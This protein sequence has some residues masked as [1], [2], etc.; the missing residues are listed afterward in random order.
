MSQSEGSSMQAPTSV[1]AILEDLVEDAP[2][3]APVNLAVFWKDIERRLL[4]QLRDEER[5]NLPL[6]KSVDPVEAERSRV[7]YERIR[8]LAWEVAVSIELGCVH[9]RALGLIA[10]LLRDQE[11]RHSRIRQT[12][13]SPE[14]LASAN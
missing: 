4:A 14:E 10:T 13:T 9:M 5:R 11:R 3:W 1:I 6:W 7:E 8:N 12:G 2:F